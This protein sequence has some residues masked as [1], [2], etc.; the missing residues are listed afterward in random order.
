[1]SS[2]NL[3]E[4]ADPN[5]IFLTKFSELE[6]R[7]DPHFHKLEFKNIE[8]RINLS[9]FDT[10]KLKDLFEINR[11]GSPRPINQYFTNDNNGINWIKIG[12]TKGIDKYICKTKQKI[13]PEGV[14][15]SRMVFEGD[16]LL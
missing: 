7:F 9:G 3:S 11:G 16:F 5:K 6:G 4:Q 8:N 14:K 12:D 13:K 10:P 2:F 15:F 1:M